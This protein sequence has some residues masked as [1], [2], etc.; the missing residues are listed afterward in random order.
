MRLFKLS[1]VV[2]LSAIVA[3]STPT[4]ATGIPVFDAANFANMLT[5]ISSWGQQYSQMVSQIT[6]MQNNVARV[7][8]LTTKFDGGRGLGAILNDSF[9]RSAMPPEIQNASL[10]LTNAL[11]GSQVASINS[12]LTSYGIPSS[13]PN[14]GKAEATQIANMQTVLAAAKQRETNLASLA[15][16]VDTSPDA[17]SSM[18]LMNRNVLELASINNQLM[19]TMAMSEAGRN[20]ANLRAQSESIASLQAMAAAQKA[21]R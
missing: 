15:S 16:Q 20:A 12:I 11:S 7:T 13:L 9:V 5:T 14:A 1:R 17:K 21:S 18:D 10:I 19:Q 6:E 8:T 4:F 2:A 3:V